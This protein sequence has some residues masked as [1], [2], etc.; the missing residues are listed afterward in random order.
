M[1]TDDCFIYD[2]R[3]DDGTFEILQSLGMAVHQRSEHAPS[4]MEHEGRFRQEAWDAFAR[5]FK[6]TSDDWILAVDADEFLVLA[7]SD[8]T[9]PPFRYL[10]ALRRTLV[11]FVSQSSPW[12]RG[13]G[14]PVKEAWEL[15][16]LMVRTDG[17]W[18]S[19]VSARLA[20]WSDTA[21]I[22]N[23]SLG[24][25]SVPSD[26]LS[27]HR[28][29]PTLELLHLGYADPLDREAKFERYWNKPGHNPRHIASIKA[30]YP[31]LSELRVHPMVSLFLDEGTGINPSVWVT[32]PNDPV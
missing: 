5:E 10:E 22:N 20:R 17:F 2:D 4:F 23:L 27:V 21:K 32:P 28:V 26:A 29:H 12:T 19:G 8:A 3:S 11:N 1:I 7:R 31:D 13:L 6:P 18:G 9:A 25:G 14:F 15:N 30:P 24:C 16:P